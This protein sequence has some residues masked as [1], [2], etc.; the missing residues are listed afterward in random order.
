VV[1]PQF[2]SGGIQVVVNRA[3]R[4]AP[5]QQLVLSLVL[6]NLWNNDVAVA[7]PELPMI[8]TESGG[9]ATARQISGVPVSTCGADARRCIQMG[10]L[11]PTVID[12]GNSITVTLVFSAN[13]NSKACNLDFSMP[14]VIQRASTSSAWQQIAVG[15]PNIRVC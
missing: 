15:L 12:R 10:A 1:Q 3:V 8:I 13:P 6:I 5:G 4:P 7:A 14:L 9:V 11:T 2:R